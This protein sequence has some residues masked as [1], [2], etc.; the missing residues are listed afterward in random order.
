MTPSGTS[1]MILQ[2]SRL[3]VVFGE[4]QDCGMTW[5]GPAPGVTDFG[6]LLRVGEAARRKCGLIQLA[7]KGTE[8]EVLDSLLRICEVTIKMCG[9]IQ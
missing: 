4:W 7:R 8:G 9:G 6:V 3:Y 5:I 1:P 2:P